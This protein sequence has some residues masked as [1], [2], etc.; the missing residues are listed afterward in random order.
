[1]W[2]RRIAVAGG[3]LLAA[4]VSVRAQEQV[5]VFAAIVDEKGVPPAK[6]GPGDVRVIE[7]GEPLKVVKVEPLA[8]PLKV[9]VL[10]D[11]GVGLGAP[12]I[13]S[14]RDG[15]RGLLEALPEGTEVTLVTTSPQPRFIARPTT[16]RAAQLK[17]LDL[18][19]P[20]TGAGRFVEA[21]NEAAQRIEK[22]KT[23]YFPVIVMAGTTAG[24]RDVRERD[25]NQ[26]MQR[27]ARRPTL[28]HVIVLA[29][30]PAANASG[31]ANQTNVGMAVTKLTGGRYEGVNSPPILATLL[32]DMGAQVA[33]SYQALG[34]QFRI[35][36]ERTKS[37]DLGRISA[38]ALQGLKVVSVALDVRLR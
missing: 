36:A 32:P 3:V 8:W 33:T 13:G 20:D 5:Q 37:G 28:V 25:I 24:D 2:S 17:G 30:G 34:R 29:G 16:D 35:T 15:V 12:Y 4:T 19:A 7:D 18:L 38:G 26:L 23:E 6:L 9:Q 1:M 11:N 14:L 21:L 10:V 22:D 31:G 27:L